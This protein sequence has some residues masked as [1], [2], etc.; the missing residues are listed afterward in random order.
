MTW[1]PASGTASSRGYTVGPGQ[2]RGPG[3]GGDLVPSACMQAPLST[4]FL[5]TWSRWLS[6]HDGFAPHYQHA[7]RYEKIK[8]NRGCRNGREVNRQDD[9]GSRPSATSARKATHGP[10]SGALHGRR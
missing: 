9:H 10:H 8:R 1:F 4:L 3:D 2:D 6:P 7:M 5:V